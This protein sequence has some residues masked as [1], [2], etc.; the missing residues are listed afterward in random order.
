MASKHLKRRII[1]YV[2]REMQTKTTMRY[3]YTSIR[4]AKS[5]NTDTI[6]RQQGCGAIG[7]LIYYWW[8][9]KTLQLLWKTVWQFLTEPNM[10][11]LQDPAIVLLGIYSKDLKTYIYNKTC[12]QM[13]ISSLIIIAKTQE[14]ARC[15]SVG[16]WTNK[17]THP[18][19]G[20]LFNAKKK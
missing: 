5:K 14:Q 7:T 2:N 9:G 1:P 20:I 19:S 17:L 6:Q 15:P 12:T 4:M 13:F 8:E 11:L 16:E 10:L 18:D 3:H